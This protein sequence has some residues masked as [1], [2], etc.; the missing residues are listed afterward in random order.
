MGPSS[1]SQEEKIASFPDENATVNARGKTETAAKWSKT[2]LN[3]LN[4]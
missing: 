1:T 2:Y 4:K 3:R